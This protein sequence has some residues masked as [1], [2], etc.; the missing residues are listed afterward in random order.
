[1]A[2]TSK[3]LWS[4][5]MLIKPHH[6]QQYDRW[7]DHELTGRTLPLH[8]YG[9][10]LLRLRIAQDALSVGRFGLSDVAAILPDGTLLDAPGHGSLPPAR[11]VPSTIKNGLVYLAVPT[12]AQDAADISAE[13]VVRRFQA[14]DQAIKD[15]SRP[16]KAPTPLRVGVPS[17]LFL[18]EG[19]PDAERIA[20]PIARIREVLAS[21]A[22]VLDETYIP[23]CLEA[24]VSLRLM[25]I[26]AELRALLRA[27][28][29]ALVSGLDPA[30]AA[31]ESASL[32]D[33]LV[34]YVI[35]GQ[36]AVLDHL[37][38]LPCVHPE[39]FFREIVRLAGQ[40]ATFGRDRR[41]MV[42]FAPYDHNDLALALGGI[43]DLLRQQLAVVIERNVI[44][45][46]LQDRGYGIRTA[47]IADRTIFQ[48]CQF[49]LVALAEMPSEQLRASLPAAMKVGSV[50]QI[51]ELVN[52]QLPGVP[53]RA[54]PVAPRS[55]PFIQNAVYFELD[56]G[57]ERWRS[58]TNSAA[59]AFHVSGEFPNLHVEFWAIRGA[60]G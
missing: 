36:Q 35:N 48:D 45:L 27:R 24:R 51:R 10:G 50:E 52:L 20:M 18:F 43:L 32:L 58:L 9:W 29:E 17:A 56:Q 60:R 40:L 23:P 14:I 2:L 12:R 53:M 15:T 47:M 6:F 38:A 21:G 8:S 31:N 19:E 7:I 25:E 34:L 28:S 54:L 4:E 11:A 42:E 59:F 16:E 30:R 22:V 41:R 49:V 39:Q 1:M 5:G 37:S 33:M 57:H 44:A 46:P 26:V 3:P 13:G 55:L